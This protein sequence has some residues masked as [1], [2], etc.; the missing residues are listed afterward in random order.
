M[1]LTLELRKEVENLLH[2]D[3]A[4]ERRPVEEVAA[5][6]LSE[7]YGFENEAYD[8]AELDQTAIEAILEGIEDIKAGRTIS[9]E[10]LRAQSEA[11]R[12]A[13]RIAEADKTP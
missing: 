2:A 10:E 6:R 8:E 11:E 1:G 3:A 5:E 4:R 9:L 12:A 13:R 7:W